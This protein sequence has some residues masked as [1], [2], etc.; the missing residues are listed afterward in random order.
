MNGETARFT[1]LPGGQLSSGGD[2]PGRQ[3]H[4]LWFSIS[5]RPWA[6]LVL[7]PADEGLSVGWIATALADVG[8]R[9]RDTP[10]TAVLAEDVDYASVRALA[11]MQPR[12]RELPPWSAAVDVVATP[13]SPAGGAVPEPSPRPSPA[14]VPL[15]RAIIAVRSVVHEPIALA[16]VHASDAAVI[17]VRMGTSRTSAVRRTLELVGP[18][19]VLGAVLVR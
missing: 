17:C 7:V 14:A 18:E 10:V 11:D 1:V 3:F 6:S 16:V 19:C 2:P 13:V 12:L 8:T 9:L 15:G 4:E 5:R